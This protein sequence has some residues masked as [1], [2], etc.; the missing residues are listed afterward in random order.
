M[1]ALAALA[2]ERSFGLIRV[3]HDQNLLLADVRQQ[4]LHDTW[5]ALRRENLATPNIGTPDRHDCLP[6]P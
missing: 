6:G 4:D 3:A 2:D 5:L 1:T